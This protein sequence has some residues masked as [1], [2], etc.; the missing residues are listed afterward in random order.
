M[1]KVI[2]N[3]S[4]S[5]ALS[6]G[7]MSTISTFKYSQPKPSSFSSQNPFFLLLGI[8]NFFAPVIV[9]AEQVSVRLLELFQSTRKIKQLQEYF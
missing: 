6:S 8:A 7:K 5:T 1:S 4:Q 9:E 2:A 3:Q